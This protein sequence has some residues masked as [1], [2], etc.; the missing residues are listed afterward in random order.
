MIQEI[1]TSNMTD[2][3]EFTDVIPLPDYYR[4]SL[5]AVDINNRMG[6]MQF[7]AM[8]WLGGPIEGIV[9][10]ELDSSP[11]TGSALTT[12]LQTLGY[13]KPIY[14]A[15]NTSRYPLEQTLDA[16]FVPLGIYPNN[17]QLS[18]VEAEVL[19]QYLE[20]GGNLYMEGGDTWYFDPQTVLHPMFSIQPVADGTGD[21]NVIT[22][23]AGTFTES[24]SFNYNGEN[25]WID[26]IDPISPAFTIFSN[27]SPSYNCAVAYSS[28]TY[29][30]I[31]ASFEFG[32]LVDS[33]PPSTKIQLLEA[34]LDF[35]NVIVP[36]ELTSFS[37]KLVDD[38]V[39]LNWSTASELNNLGFEIERSDGNK[40]FLRLGFVEGHGTTTEKQEYLFT[41]NT[42]LNEGNYSYRLKQIDLDGTVTY[43]EVI[44]IEFNN[45][46]T[47]FTLY[48]NY[49]NPFNNSTIIKYEVPEEKIVTIRIYNAIGEDVVTLVNE[50]KKAGRYSVT[51]N[52]DNLP[53]AIYF[54]RIATDN[55]VETKKMIL[56]K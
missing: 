56:L 38:N 41:D 15:Q 51:F 48:Q 32:G 55:F 9:I 42:L 29:R 23:K 11:I 13:Y 8:D 49:P 36:V 50:V 16:V 22:G 18:D 53:S 52:A 39:I 35:F 3:L 31:G 4:Y 33:S 40:E 28:G 20:Q 7:H 26:H 43:S 21:L 17:H 1:F 2:T 19:K 6:Q 37:A 14:I 44:E 34:M 24:M 27:A 25:S 30:T 47:S 12:S 45:L 54:Y 10:I 5:C 46:P